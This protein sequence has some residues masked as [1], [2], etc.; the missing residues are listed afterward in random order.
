MRDHS[1]TRGARIVGHAVAGGAAEDARR[2]V[3]LQT[4]GHVSVKIRARNEPDR[5]GKDALKTR[6]VYRSR[7]ERFGVGSSPG[8]EAKRRCPCRP[9]AGE[10]LAAHDRGVADAVPV[11]DDGPN[12]LRGGDEVPIRAPRIATIST[13]E[14]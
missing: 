14:P 10:P 6:N 11:A 12:V 4:I 2:P 5:G 7:A 8:E 13:P 1:D 3:C 9:A